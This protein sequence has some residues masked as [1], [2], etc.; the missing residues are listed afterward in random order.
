MGHPAMVSCRVEGSV[1]MDSSHIWFGDRNC[2]N[3]SNGLDN[4]SLHPAL[5]AIL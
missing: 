1:G 5:D 4:V 2:W 3:Y